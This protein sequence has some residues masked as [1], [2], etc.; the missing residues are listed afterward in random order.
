MSV[1]EANKNFRIIDS[2]ICLQKINF[3]YLYLF[4]VAT[5]SVI[6]YGQNTQDLKNYIKKV[7]ND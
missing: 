1:H 3:Y 4:F 7:Y 2:F 5:F 6:I